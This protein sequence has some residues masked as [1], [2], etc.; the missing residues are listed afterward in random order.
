MATP[1]LL[2]QQKQMSCLFL[3]IQSDVYFIKNK[4]LQ[5]IL[6]L[7]LRNACNKMRVNS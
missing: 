3:Q 2:R 1:L 7:Y 4:Y 6:N 5:L